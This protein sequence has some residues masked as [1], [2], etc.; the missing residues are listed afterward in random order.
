MDF[1]VLSH[2]GLAVSGAGTTLLCDPW[3]VGSC[4]WRSWWNYPPPAA[5]LIASL[6]PDVISLSHIHWDH[7]HGVSLRRFPRD[8]PVLVPRGHHDRMR[9]DLEWLGF[10]DVRELRHGRRIELGPDFGVTSYQF[11]PFL[12]S[13]LVIETE[14]VTLFNVTDAKL[15]GR[16]L[17]QV[18]DRH[19][20]IDFVF[21]SHSSANGR[22]CFEIT[23]D[24]DEEVDDDSRYVRSF[25]DFA[26]RSG[27]RHAIP[28]ASNHCFLH[29]EVVGLNHT[30]KT[31]QMVLDEMATRG[32]T[33]PQA[34]VLV[35]GDSWSSDRGFSVAPNDWFTNRDAHLASYQADVADK[36]EATYA[37]EEAARVDEEE[38]RRYF[39]R[40]SGALP[41][42][43]RRFFRGRPIVYVLA[44]GNRRDALSVD[45]SR[46]TVTRVAD[47]DDRVHPVQIHTAAH[48]F[49][50]CI[51]R[52]LFSHL[53]I[54]KR[55]RYRT[56]SAEKRT[57][58]VLNLTF[59]LYEYDYL[60]LRKTI[61]RRALVNWLDRW[62][63]ILLYLR[64]AADVVR[65]RGIDVERYV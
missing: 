20:D 49:N 35:S 12:D 24:P 13:A 41:F 11:G 63:E 18:L 53:P 17:E 15:M 52:D 48:L 37:E 16:P 36:L 3:L 38:M 43:L 28:F 23:D 64:V 42:P 47:V 32:I 45:L 5:E 65:R 62:R 10:T 2:A 51:Q 30:I 4:Y 1:T 61:S 54:S 34:H 31:P 14:G 60:P 44:A 29:R 46:G 7:F 33:T 27:A 57:V 39:S 55:V 6:Q 21:R 25:V 9:R 22:L 58:Q 50:Q 40:L 8:T 19:P 56:T 59:N 26:V